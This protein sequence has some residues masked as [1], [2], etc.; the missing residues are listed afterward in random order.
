LSAEVSH[1]SLANRE[2]VTTSTSAEH[3]EHRWADDRAPLDELIRQTPGAH[4]IASI[5]ELRSDAFET[6][7]ELDEFLVFVAE[8]RHAGLA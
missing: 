3:P 6:D 7:E 1:W 2:M 4:P 5:D 8:S